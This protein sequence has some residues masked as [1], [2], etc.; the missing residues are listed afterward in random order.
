MTDFR[1]SRERLTRE[2]DAGRSAARQASASEHPVLTQALVWGRFDDR[3][4]VAHAGRSK[5]VRG[6]ALVIATGAYDR[7]VAFPGWTLPGVMSAGGAQTLAKTQWV[8][9]GQRMLLAG[10]RAV[11]ATCRAISLFARTSRSRPFVEATRPAEWLRHAGCALGAVAALR[12][13]LGL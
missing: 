5:T 6:Q 12:R 11:P 7:P 8:K 2:H 4:M 9:P 13:S 1:S 3:I 10:R